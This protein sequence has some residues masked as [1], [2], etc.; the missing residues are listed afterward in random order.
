VSGWTPPY[1]GSTTTTT[2]FNTNDQGVHP[3]A[4]TANPIN[5]TFA[6]MTD[7]NIPGGCDDCDAHQ[8]L[9]QKPRI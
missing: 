1:R 6:S 8:R 9:N 3:M 7:Q 2:Y 5:D 4:E